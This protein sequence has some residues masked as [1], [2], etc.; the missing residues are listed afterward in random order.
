MIK[1]HAY[2][3]YPAPLA[4]AVNGGNVVHVVRI[5]STS[6]QGPHVS[7]IQHYYSIHTIIFTL[8][9]KMYH[10]MPGLSKL[11]GLVYMHTSMWCVAHYTMLIA[12]ILI[13]ML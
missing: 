5:H 9:I 13:Y 10:H 4:A 12:M 1:K 7:S 6:S 2:S 3:I 11:R 8:M